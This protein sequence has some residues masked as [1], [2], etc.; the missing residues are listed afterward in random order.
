MRCDATPF[1]LAGL[2]AVPGP[3][4]RPMSWLRRTLFRKEDWQI[5]GPTTEAD[6]TAALAAVADS[7]MPLLMTLPKLPFNRAYVGRVRDGKIA[8]K[9][10]THPALWLVRPG[11]YFFPGRLS[12]QGTGIAVSGAYRPRPTLAWMYYAYFAIGATILAISLLA[13]VLG[14]ALWVLVA[15]ADSSV[16]Y[17]GC[18]MVLISCAYMVLGWAHISFESH[19]DAR[20]NRH[21]V[22]RLLERAVTGRTGSRVPRGDGDSVGPP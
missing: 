17:E 7:G 16:L 22:R 14:A 8:V 13:T 3:F 20:R 21:A 10:R 2:A 9:H 6:F 12:E 15:A 4:G 11:S 19:L 1:R 18:K 5:G